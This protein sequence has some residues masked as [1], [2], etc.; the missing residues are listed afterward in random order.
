MSRLRVLLL[1]AIA[2]MMLPLAAQSIN[3]RPGRYETVV[4]MTMPNGTKMP[5]KDTDCLTAAD[6][7]DVSKTFLEDLGSDCKIS[8]LKNTGKQMS[9]TAT[10]KED[11]GTMTMTADMTFSG[12]SYSSTIK[13]KTGKGETFDIT[14]TGKR[15]GECSGRG[16]PRR[17]GLRATPPR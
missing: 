8:N 7:K 13:S 17:F 5:I 11:A 12:D 14:M 15:L 10:C 9:F 4:E 16:L 3:L 2:S 6:L 1:V